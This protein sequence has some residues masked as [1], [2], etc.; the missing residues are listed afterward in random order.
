MRNVVIMAGG[1][2]TRLWPL[3]RSNRP[4]QLLEL[5]GGTSLL[6]LAYARARTLVEPAR[7]YVCT[8][9]EYADQV[10]ELLSE[11][12]A[13]NVIGE[14]IGRDTAAAVAL[15]AAVVGRDGPDASVAMITADHIITPPRNFTAAVAA[16]FD[17]VEADPA[18]VCTFGITPAYAHTGLG[19][20]EQG[21]PITGSPEVE[22][23]AVA[24]FRE[25]PDRATAEE[26]LATGRFRWNSG[27][28]VWRCD[29]IL[30]VMEVLLPQTATAVRAIAGGWD[31]PDRG[32]IEKAYPDLPKIS[33]DYAVLEPLTADD[34]PQELA[35]EHVVMLPMDVQWL[36]VG[37][38]PA[39]SSTYE[40]DSRGNRKP[41]GALVCLVDSGENV[42]ISSDPDH[43]IGAIGLH[44]QLLVHTSDATLIC[45]LDEADRLKELVAAIEEQTGGR[46]T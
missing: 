2:G 9:A 43:L 32:G 42:L 1:S 18:A 28:F 16:G 39:L 27:M 14:P 8:S 12:P 5:T 23:Y 3:S 26:Y 45:P 35:D 37:S 30:R 36:D 6:E 25:K 24:R 21:E 17:V 31:A 11:L 41:T 33:I 29:T 22:A 15:S 19:Y 4:K 20:V 10:A 34:R 46:Y 44:R 13:G 38:F 7:I 40:T